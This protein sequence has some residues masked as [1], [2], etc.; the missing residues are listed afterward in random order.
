MARSQ[1]KSVKDLYQNSESKSSNEGKYLALKSLAEANK[2]DIAA[3]RN[4]LIQ[5]GDE[6]KF[7]E[8]IEEMA[9]SSGIVY[10]ITSI[11]VKPQN[12]FKED[13]SV[14]MNVDGSWQRIMSFIDKLEKTSFGITVQS[15]NVDHLLDKGWNG[16]IE[17]TIYREK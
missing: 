8:A 10:E 5:K 9:T 14:R 13:I 16:V 17:F 3:L 11:D 7:I 2:D 6:V 4:F 12:G 1:S 15:L